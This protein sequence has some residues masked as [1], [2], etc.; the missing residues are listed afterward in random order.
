MM[1]AINLSWAFGG[2]VVGAIAGMSLQRYLRRQLNDDNENPPGGSSPE[3][4]GN[5][6]V[7]DDQ[8]PDG[9]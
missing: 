3:K 4:K 6:Y 9:R 2:L 7:R 8:Y 1:D 5:Y